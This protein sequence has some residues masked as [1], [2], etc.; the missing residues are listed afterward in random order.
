MSIIS[1]I[2]SATA[3]QTTDVK[4]TKTSAYTADYGKTVG[5]PQLSEKAAK[6]YESLKKKYGNMDFV[7]VSKDMKETAKSQV[8]SYANPYRMVVLVDEEKIERMAEDEAYRAKYEGLIEKASSG[9]SQL[10]AKTAD[11][12]NV[13]GFGMQVNDNGTATFFAVLKDS[14]KAQKA[15]IEKKAAENKEAKKE[16]AKKAEEKRAEEAKAEKAEKSDWNDGGIYIDDEAGDVLIQASSVEELLQ[17]IS[18]YEYNL[19]ADSVMTESEKAIGGHID[20]KG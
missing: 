10:R 19:R 8:G 11:N 13:K 4:E 15:R 18:D 1:E 3:K 6:Y 14:S 17:K 2:A 16:A 5:K 20:F 7:L 12:P 9:I